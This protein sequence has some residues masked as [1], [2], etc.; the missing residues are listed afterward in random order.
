[1]L[2]QKL[3]RLSAIALFG[4]AMANSVFAIDIYYKDK[5]VPTDTSPVVELWC[6]F[7]P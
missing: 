4:I 6:P 3:L 5:L 7:L 1:M 2:K